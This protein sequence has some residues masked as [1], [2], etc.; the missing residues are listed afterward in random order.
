MCLACLAQV[1]AD[2]EPEDASRSGD[3]LLPLKWTAD[4][5]VI[6]A[7]LEALRRDADPVW[8]ASDTTVLHVPTD[9]STPPSEC[10]RVAGPHTVPEPPITV[11]RR[12]VPPRATAG[13]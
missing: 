6:A 12:E 2:P 5:A 1:P 7:T 13:C 11:R 3:A 4:V 8:T 10:A 9:W